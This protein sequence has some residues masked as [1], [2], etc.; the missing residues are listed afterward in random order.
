MIS[1]HNSIFLCKLCNRQGENEFGSNPLRT[2]DIDVFVVGLDNLLYNGKPQAGP[3]F[4]LP[5]GSVGLIE[6]F[7]DFFQAVLGDA[8]SGVLDGY[9]DLIVPLGGFHGD[10][11]IRMA[12]LDGVVDEVVHDLL[13]FTHICGHKQ[14]FSRKN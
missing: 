11:G 9:K 6:A 4:I 10:G 7:P 12:E 14:F 1:L 3:F 5:P 2:D 8:D 13:D